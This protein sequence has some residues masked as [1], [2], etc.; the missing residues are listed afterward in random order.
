MHKAVAVLS[1]VAG[2][3]VL[4]PSAL[5][6][7]P[8]VFGGDVAC[9][10][11]ADGVRGNGGRGLGLIEGEE[12]CPADAEGGDGEG[13][14]EEFGGEEASI[15]RAR[16]GVGGVVGGCFGWLGHGLGFGVAGIITKFR[17]VVLEPGR[18]G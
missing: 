5:A 8:S 1:I 16:C 17:R 6:D 18:E 4:A 15:G 14:P 3:L 9:T 11:A 7:I 12:D 13:E 2:S 10:E